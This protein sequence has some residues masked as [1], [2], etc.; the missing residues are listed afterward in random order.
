[1]TKK[2]DKGEARRFRQ[3][4]VNNSKTPSF[5]APV[6]RDASLTATVQKYS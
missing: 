6:S 5:L 3:T 4:N 2:G 1:M